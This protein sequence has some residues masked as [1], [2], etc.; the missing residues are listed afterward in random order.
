MSISGQDLYED[1]EPFDQGFIDTRDGHSIYWECCGNPNGKP[2][3]YLHGGPGSGFA[4]WTRRLFDPTAYKPLL[5]HR[6]QLASNTTQHLL[7]DLEMIRKHLTVDRWI[8]LGASWGSTLAL[9]YAEMFPD[10]VAAIVLAGVTT[11]SR[12]EVEWIT[13]DVGRIFPK[14]WERFTAHIPKALKH[15]SIVDAYAK[16]LFDDDPSVCDAAAAE[17]NAWEEAHVSLAS[18]G[19]RSRR[20]DDAGFRLRFARIVTHYWRHAGFLE[21]GQILLNS[22]KL[23]SIPGILL[24]GRYDVSSPLITAWTLQQHWAGSELTIVNDGHGGT[25]LARCIVSALN[26]FRSS[27]R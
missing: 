27:A 14:Q 19:I 10:R 25:H 3:V 2:A 23:R 21:E 24:H 4:P 5:S 22:S 26:R 17:W 18:G 9:A 20:Y 8:M 7:A 15:L 11:T 16:L 6:S 13:Y 12:R 1:I